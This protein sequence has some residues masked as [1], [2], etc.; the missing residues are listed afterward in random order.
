MPPGPVSFPRVAAG[1]CL[2]DRSVR[3]LSSANRLDHLLVDSPV[4]RN[5]FHAARVERATGEIADAATGLLDDERARGD[6]PRVEADLPEP[7][8]PARGDVGEIDRGGAE[9]PHRT[10]AS[11]EVAE[12]PQ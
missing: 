11:N 8:E 9:T 12:Q 4:G 2:A 7:I 6:V 10:R 5:H 3:P 1:G